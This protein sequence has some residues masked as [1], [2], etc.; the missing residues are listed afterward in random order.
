M[1]DPFAGS[2]SAG[3]RSTPARFRETVALEHLFAKPASKASAT[4]R[5]SFSAPVTTSLT[6]AS[7]SG[8]T[9]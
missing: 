7:I 9:P 6:D 2:G 4:A 8:F 3:S 1:N 5:G